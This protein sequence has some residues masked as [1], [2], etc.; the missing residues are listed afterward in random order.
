MREKKPVPWPYW[1]L[2]LASLG[3]ALVLFYVI[4]TPVWMAIRALAWLSGRGA[5]IARGVRATARSGA[6][7]G[8]P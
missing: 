1:L 8:S 2:W 5:E 6:P 7:R 4:L 3:L